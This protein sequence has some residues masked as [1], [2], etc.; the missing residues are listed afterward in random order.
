MS[1]FGVLLFLQI[2]FVFKLFFVPWWGLVDRLW[3]AMGGGGSEAKRDTGV[4]T[5]ITKTKH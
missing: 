4:L 2:I 5:D 3:G 1:N